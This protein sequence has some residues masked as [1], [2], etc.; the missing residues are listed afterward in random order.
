MSEKYHLG[1]IFLQGKN[2]FQLGNRVKP[3][4]FFFLVLSELLTELALFS[5]PRME[6]PL[7]TPQDGLGSPRK[8][9]EVTNT[10]LGLNYSELI[11]QHM[12]CL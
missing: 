1:I 3:E 5:F 6:V 10:S 7:I 4:P 8:M 9:Q 12:A 2:F 11:I